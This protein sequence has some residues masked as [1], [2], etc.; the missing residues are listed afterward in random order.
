MES[1]AR[2]AEPLKPSKQQTKKTT[3]LQL[4]K[5]ALSLHLVKS[6]APQLF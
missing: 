6:D 3:P 4:L 5:R 2:K 1:Q